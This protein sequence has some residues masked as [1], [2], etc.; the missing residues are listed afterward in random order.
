MAAA[1]DVHQAP[2][3]PGRVLESLDTVELESSEPVGLLELGNQ[4]AAGKSAESTRTGKG[5][6]RAVV[7]DR[8]VSEQHLNHPDIGASHQR[9]R[10]EGVPQR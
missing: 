3:L 2:S 10:R 7:P 6:S 4:L 1:L 9:V 5:Q 8:R